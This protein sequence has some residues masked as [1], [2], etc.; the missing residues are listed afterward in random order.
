MTIYII[1]I[2]FAILYMTLYI[3]YILFAMLRW[4]Q[5][6]GYFDPY[7]APNTGPGVIQFQ[8]DPSAVPLATHRLNVLVSSIL[9]GCVCMAVG[10]ALAKRHM[11]V[12]GGLGLGA[13][14]D[15]GAYS[16]ISDQN[17]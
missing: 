1:Y 6:V 15:R 12:A 17:L 9:S 11:G 5:A 13:N 10:V 14:T 2:L 8:P 16:V 4:L 3:I 7:N